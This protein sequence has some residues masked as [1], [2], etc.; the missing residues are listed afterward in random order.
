[1]ASDEELKKIENQEAKILEK[2]QKIEQEEAEILKVDKVVAGSIKDF[3][4]LRSN[5]AR[6]I[7]KHRFIYTLLISLGV[8]MV[9]RGMWELT[10]SIITSSLVSLGLGVVLL[11]LIKKHTDIH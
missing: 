6:R 10:E 8:V 7:A 5:F 11:W 3:S 2:E 9:W 1:M 4:Q